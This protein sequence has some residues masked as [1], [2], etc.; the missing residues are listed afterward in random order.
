MAR[1]LLKLLAFGTLGAAL[2]FAFLWYDGSFKRRA[3]FNEVGRCF[4]QDTGVVYHAQSGAVW[5]SLAL[6]ALCGFAALVWCLKRL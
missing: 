6:L 1:P 3:C 4:D 5:L 2:V